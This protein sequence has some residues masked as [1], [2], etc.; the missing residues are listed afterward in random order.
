M[1]ILALGIYFFQRSR[2]LFLI[3]KW[4]PIARCYGIIL[5]GLVIFSYGLITWFQ[6]VLEKKEINDFSIYRYSRHP[7]YL[8]YLLWSYG[9]YLLTLIPK[10]W[11]Y[12]SIH[13]DY[14]FIWFLFN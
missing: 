8:G 9:I 6:G 11:P 3:G 4:L 13:F 12:G 7:Q 5:I 14:T 2:C 1:G 10:G